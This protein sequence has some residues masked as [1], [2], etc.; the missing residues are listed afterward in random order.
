M[1]RLDYFGLVKSQH[2]RLFCS[3]VYWPEK[4]GGVV[5]ISH[6]RIEMEVAIF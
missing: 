3:W 1:S 6:K 4:G 5:A 2:L